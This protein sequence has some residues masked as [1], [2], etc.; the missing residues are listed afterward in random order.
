MNGIFNKRCD[1][2]AFYGVKSGSDEVFT[3]MQGFTALSVSKNPKTYKRR[4][5]DEP[6]EQTDV[7][8]YAPEI[9]YAF[10]RFTG[11]SV[12][13]DIVKIT[14]GELTGQECIR[15]IIIV[16]LTAPGGGGYPAIKRDFA[17]IPSS[18]G[19]EGEVYSY[20]GKLMVKGEMV[21]GTAEISDNICTF[22]ANETV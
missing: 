5:V 1:K 9:S 12:H 6:Y 19:G 17:V 3:K 22:T 13:D 2:L 15:S 4:Y 16:D 20:T 10:D 8:G 7:V 14:D 18:E 11:N 21:V